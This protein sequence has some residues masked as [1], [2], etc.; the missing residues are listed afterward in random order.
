[1]KTA[2]LIAALAASL[3]SPLALAGEDA[4]PAAAVDTRS[5]DAAFAK[6]MDESGIV[7]AGAAVLV[8]GKVV[9][10]KGYGFADR[11]RA[12][13]F[14]PDTVMN[15][16]SISKT[17][18]GAA[19]MR[20]VE[21]GRLSLDTDIN[22]WLPFKVVNPH[23]PGAVITLR[24]LA[25]HTSGITDRWA[26]YR[27]TYHFDG[28]PPEPLAQF[29]HSYF[30]P[31]GK[32]YAPDNFLEAAP[33]EQRAYS[34]IAAALAGY[35]VERVV[36]QPLEAY[37]AAHIF[38]PLAM[39]NTAWSL[40]A[41]DRARHSTLHMSDGVLAA[42]IPLYTGTTYPDGGV[43]TSV[44][45]LSR[46]FAALLGNGAYEGG[47]ILQPPSVEEMKRFQFTPA[48][49]PKNIELAN[50]N[51]GL[52]WATKFGATR[53]GH[54]GSDP[55]IKTEMLASLN[56]DVGVILFSNTSLPGEMDAYFVMLEELWKFAEAWRDSSRKPVAAH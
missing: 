16:G 47:R 35:I 44:S 31:G 9:W 55:G 34:N 3:C 32:N 8:D 24:H 27:T 26:V 4:S 33:G 20:A 19:M 23:R 18:T 42:P 10:T 13:P 39:K 50:K 46:F 54:G 11:D 28:A 38:N 29:L 41:V 37:A 48:R 17:F 7:G 25:T 5:L 15:I 14:T 40:P 49:K 2:L 6:H 30:A 45:D 1:M 22:T 52:F 53:V 56:G 43:R 51:S 21:E 12:V 36:G